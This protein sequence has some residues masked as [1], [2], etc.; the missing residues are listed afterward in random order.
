MPDLRTI[1][2]RMIDAGDSDEDIQGVIERFNEL[3]PPTPKT[4]FSL[5]D[6]YKGPDDFWGGVKESFKPG[7]EVDKAALSGFGGFLRG[8]VADIPETLWTAA[9]DAFQVASHPIQTLKDAPAA[10]SEG[11][12]IV[13]KQMFD[14]TVNAG[15]DPHSFGRM[16]GQLTGQPAVTAH[17]RP[18]IGAPTEFA[19]K[20]MR[21]YQPMTGVMP[22]MVEPRLLR[23]LERGVGRGVENLGQRIRGTHKPPEPPINPN[24]GGALVRERAPSVEDVFA[25]AIQQIR[26][27]SNRA[28]SVEAAPPAFER[29]APKTRT[30]SPGMSQ[31][32]TPLK[33]K[34]EIAEA[35]G[36]TKKN[37][38]AP[39]QAPA[40]ETFEPS[41]DPATGEIFEP[42]VEAGPPKPRTTRSKGR[43]SP[44]IEPVTTAAETPESIVQ[45][46]GLTPELKARIL[47]KVKN[48]FSADNV[49][50]SAAIPESADNLATRVSRA[51]DR[52]KGG[53]SPT[54][55]DIPEGQITNRRMFELSDQIG[56]E[57]T[58]AQSSSESSLFSDIPGASEF[59]PDLVPL[60]DDVFEGA[61]PRFA[62]PLRSFEDIQSRIYELMDK[63]QAGTLTGPE[64]TEAQQLNKQWRNHPEFGQEAAPPPA[65][66]PSFFDRFKATMQDET[67]SVPRLRKGDKL[68]EPKNLGG[69]ASDKEVGPKGQS[70]SVHGPD[71]KHLGDI[72][73]NP[74]DVAEAM[75]TPGLE[76]IAEK[77]MINAM[78]EAKRDELL[79]THGFK[80]TDLPRMK[81]ES[82]SAVKKVAKSTAPELPAEKV[83]A[84]IEE[85]Q[86][87]LPKSETSKPVK[88]EYVDPDKAFSP[89]GDFEPIKRIFTELNRNQ[90]SD[91]RYK[92]LLPKGMQV[93]LR[94]GE[95]F[96]QRL[97]H[98][99]TSLEN[100]KNPTARAAARARA[101]ERE[102]FLKSVANPEAVVETQKAP[103]EVPL[104]DRKKID[105]SKLRSGK[106][107]RQPEPFVSERMMQQHN[108]LARRLRGM[109]P[110]KVK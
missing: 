82:K 72:N 57:N 108:A 87:T 33:S 4:D 69:V 81:I 71:G 6:E 67:G 90:A 78:F 98:L 100:L 51:F 60:M 36:P 94:E 104:L 25:N 105:V 28:P 80:E 47:D 31:F 46:S 85:I 11:A 14:T 29:G 79:E 55:P 18:L 97:I 99:I 44:T 101:I 59:S 56:A 3:H 15:A 70:W 65:P 40:K 106:I 10:F 43:F 52:I 48:L 63:D 27:D 32:G 12:P 24:A 39:K 35:T 22:R 77:D 45:A 76:G 68:I 50:G 37:N 93:A 16:M 38:A 5:K 110:K 7:G 95:T 34:A 107:N 49:E 58:A 19:G 26:N 53:K 96:K 73:V 2:N 66:E 86:E 54:A 83:T 92:P 8:A 20:M 41:V 62:A 91:L 89:E 109:P 75:A 42:P 23:N 1:V 9:K 102:N 88:S 30:D 64:L 84:P 17:A 21:K 61:S 103:T 13:G 74:A